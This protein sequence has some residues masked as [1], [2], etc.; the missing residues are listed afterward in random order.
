MLRNTRLEVAAMTMRAAF[1][2]RTT[3]AATF[4]RVRVLWTASLGF[5][6]D[7][8]DG[9]VIIPR[10]NIQ[11]QINPSVLVALS[12]GLLQRIA[13]QVL[14][15]DQESVLNQAL[16]Q[17]LDESCHARVEDQVRQWITPTHPGNQPVSLLRVADSRKSVGVPV[18][19]GAVEPRRSR[20]VQNRSLN[21]RGIV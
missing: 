3:F 10:G 5:P 8:E 6:G 9:V 20:A 4:S 15:A 17:L 2:R 7:G 21:P 12:P 14:H 18:G 16:A 13:V 19:N 1:A 11:I